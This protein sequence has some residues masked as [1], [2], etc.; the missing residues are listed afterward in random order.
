MPSRLYRDR[1]V[2]LRTHKLGESD[3][4]VT[5]LGRQKGLFR[6]VAKGVRRTSSKFGARVEPFGVV[7]AQFHEGRSLDILT[8]AE[9]IYPFGM[10]IAPD[11]NLYTAAALM[12]ECAER[13]TEASSPSAEAYDLLV[14][15]LNALARR[16]HGPDFVVSSYLLRALALEGWQPALSSCA[17][18]GQENLLFFSIVS[19]GGLCAEC[20]A[21][22]GLPAYSPDFFVLGDLLSRAA[23]GAAGQY[24][25]SLASQLV[26]VISRYAQWHLER[27]LKSLSVRER[28]Q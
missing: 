6:A 7:D 3:R 1:A 24:P 16:R 13:L 19:G 27:R 5:F 14:G 10:L 4:I 11:Y 18:C 23:W 2:V 21:G 26:T 17:L 22:E 8:Q 20:G 15:A 25:P 28:G 9:L 12:L